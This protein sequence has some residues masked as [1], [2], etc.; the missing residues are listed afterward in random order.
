MPT[1]QHQQQT[2]TTRTRKSVCPRQPTHAQHDSAL[3]SQIRPRNH[4][5][6]PSN[7]GTRKVVLRGGTRRAAEFRI[8]V[9]RSSG[10]TVDAD[11]S[12]SSGAGV[13]SLPWRRRR[14][15]AIY[16][17]RLSVV[18]ASYQALRP[19]LILAC[20]FV[21]ADPRPAGRS[22]LPTS[23]TTPDRL[24]RRSS[25]RVES[26]ARPP[27]RPFRTSAAVTR[28]AAAVLP[29]TRFHVS[30]ALGNRHPGLVTDL[31]NDVLDHRVELQRAVDPLA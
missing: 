17:P 9:G 28:D 12:Y 3:Q 15:K 31:V 27:Q 29:A 7:C 14:T 23:A 10:S 26:G 1:P 11:D 4:P 16:G 8:A 13:R 30:E 21:I 18:Q 2:A 22:S 25:Q 5:H 19:T 24:A 6:L 20:V